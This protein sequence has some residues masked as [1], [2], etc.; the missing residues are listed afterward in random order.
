MRIFCGLWFL[1]LSLASESAV[2]KIYVFGDSISDGG[3]SATAKVS[4][5]KLG[6]SPYTQDNTCTFQSRYTN[7]LTMV[8]EAAAVLGKL[9]PTSFE[10][11]AIG[12]QDTGHLG[13]QTA[14]MLSNNNNAVGSNDLVIIAI[15]ANDF[16]KVTRPSSPVSVEDATNEAMSRIRE[17][18]YGLFGAGARKIIIANV[19]DITKLPG[20]K[21]NSSMLTTA[22]EFTTQFNTKLN[23]KVAELNSAA[24]T[25]D[26]NAKIT[27]FDF[28][29]TSQWFFNASENVYGSYT[30]Y[31]PNEQAYTKCINE[32]A[33]TITSVIERSGLYNWP[34][35]DKDI[36]F[37]GVHL[38]RRAHVY[39]GHQLGEFIKANY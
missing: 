24:V 8:E 9:N 27:L 5:A 14:T 15:G 32:I 34:I 39:F 19:F 28:Y 3:L 10:N 22:G 17:V 16:H 37:D 25:H 36:F 20:V 18:V 31:D 38:T 35:F 23:A 1:V 7:G 2:Q 33:P 11:Y 26:P 29:Q 13:N 6:A 12:G 30:I 4:A 21:S